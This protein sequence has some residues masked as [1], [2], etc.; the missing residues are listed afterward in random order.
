MTTEAHAV[1]CANCGEDA[2]KDTPEPIAKFVWLCDRCE[3]EVDL[4][5]DG[6]AQP[7]Q[8]SMWITIGL[9]DGTVATWVDLPDLS[10]RI[11][12]LIGRAPDSI[13]T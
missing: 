1:T 11:E 5:L 10:D 9:S 3:H 13:K 4:A 6:E 7:D 2:P 8:E 12:A